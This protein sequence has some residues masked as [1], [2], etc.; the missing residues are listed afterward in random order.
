MNDFLNKFSNDNYNKDTK[1]ETH[2]KETESNTIKEAIEE[3]KAI[4]SVEHETEIDT[5]YNKTKTIRYVVIALTI[6]IIAV[7]ALF[8]FR[9]LNQVTVKN[10]VEGNLSDA[11]SWAL[12]NSVELD[13]ESIYNL[14]YSENIIISQDEKEGTKIQKG[15]ILYIKVSKGADPNEKIELPKFEDMTTTDINNWIFKNKINAYVLTEYDDKVENGKFIKIEFS[16]KDI[17]ESNY[18]RKENMTIYMSKGSESLNKNITVPNFK[19]KSKTEVETWA[20][21]NSITI[22]YKE[23]GSDTVLQGLVLSQSVEEG[24]KISKSD[25][26]R[27]E[28]SLGKPSIVPNFNNILKEDAA[29]LVE[30]QVTV[31][32]TYHA[33]IPYGKLISQS[34]STGTRLY[35]EDKRVDVVYS[36][37][38]P[39]IDDLVGT[40]EKTLPEY[41]YQFQSKGA[42]ITYVTTY[43]DA[44]EEKGKVV[45]VSLKNEYMNLKTEVKIQVS[46]G[47]LAP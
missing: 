11:K 15:S 18:I 45:A 12:K 13:V 1:V 8:I 36:L 25:T 29:A 31:K 24:T 30:L 23:V 41:F 19:D 37:G 42:N 46:K 17:N 44:S 6:I 3:K 40:E 27:I 35:G 21:N 38:R 9:N 34:K 28:I 16:N 22:T 2:T 26:I 5:T 10:L 47:N 4:K 43:V 7:I 33:T 39:Y 14:E 20:T 32:A